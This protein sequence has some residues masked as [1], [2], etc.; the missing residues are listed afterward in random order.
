MPASKQKTFKIPFSGGAAMVVVVA[1]W[2]LLGEEEKQ[3]K[4]LAAQINADGTTVGWRQDSEGVNLTIS[5][6]ASAMTVTLNILP[7]Y[8][9]TDCK[10]CVIPGDPFA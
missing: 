9:V 10:C 6:S 4:L 1:K 7:G 8:S 2:S 5:I 3:K